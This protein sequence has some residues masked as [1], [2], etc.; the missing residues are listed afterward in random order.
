MLFRVLKIV[1][2]WV[3]PIAFVFGSWVLTDY[4]Y[5]PGAVGSLVT[6]LSTVEEFAELNCDIELGSKATTL[7]LF[8]HPHC[9]CTKA[10]VDNLRQTVARYSKQ[11]RV[12]A[13]GFCPDE[14][15]DTWISSPLTSAL[16]RLK[17]NIF[18]DKDGE[19]CSRFGITTS[20][21]VLAYGDDG[22]LLF[23][24]GITSG[25]G[26]EGLCPATRDLNLRTSG[27]SSERVDWPV[28]GCPIIK[29]EDLQ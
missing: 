4:S 7:I 28:F 2:L 19:F 24:G 14:K 10:T 5:R 26:H 16:R 22:R 25:R 17:A 9:P 11:T 18:A 12:V 8:Y 6:D 27:R 29:S 23:S 20:G 3:C 21:H 1:L 13:F 15:P